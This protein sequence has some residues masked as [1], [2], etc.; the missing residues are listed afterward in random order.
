[1]LAVHVSHY[2]SNIR[3]VLIGEC[4]YTSYTAGV[5][6]AYKA[7]HKAL[8]GEPFPDD[9]ELLT[10]CTRV[11]D[12]CAKKDN[13][14]GQFRDILTTYFDILE[15]DGSVDGIGTAANF[16]MATYL[17]EFQP[18]FSKM[19]NAA[20]QLLQIVHRPFSGLKNV[21][22]QKTLSNCAETTMGTHLEWEYELKGKECCEPTNAVPEP[23]MLP[24]PRGEAWT[25]W[26][27][28]T[29]QDSF[30]MFQT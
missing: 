10:K 15:E 25:R 24:Q 4:S 18:G 20:R 5:M 1:M 26:T 29:W 2:Y 11:L 9:M 16:P 22:T 23:V 27:P 21:A 3:K 19:H 28:S 6:I 14:A 7:T 13:L 8:R 12:Y 30:S 17:F